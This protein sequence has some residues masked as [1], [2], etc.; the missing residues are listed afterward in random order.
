MVVKT[1]KSSDRLIDEVNLF[2]NKIS[3]TAIANCYRHQ[4]RVKNLKPLPKARMLLKAKK[5]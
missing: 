1:N 3:E 4:Y 5:Y 2:L